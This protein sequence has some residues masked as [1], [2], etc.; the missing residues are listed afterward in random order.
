MQQKFYDRENIA[1]ANGAL[2]GIAEMR[3]VETVK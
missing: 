1:L 3:C 2:F